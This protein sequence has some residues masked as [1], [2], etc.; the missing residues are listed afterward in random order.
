MKQLLVAREL[1][2]SLRHIA[3]GQE[4]PDEGCVAGFPEWFSPHGGPGGSR[5]LPPASGRREVACECFQG[6]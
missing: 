6:M 2:K 5:R 4:Y 3:F 1:T